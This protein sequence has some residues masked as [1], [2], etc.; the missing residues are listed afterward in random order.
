MKAAFIFFILGAAFGIAGLCCGFS[1]DRISEVYA[2][3][4]LWNSGSSV[5]DWTEGSSG[6]YDFEEEYTGIKSLDLAAGI[7]ECALIPYDG[8]TWLVTGSR[9]PSAF[10]CQ[11]KGSTLK[12]SF[13]GLRIF[14][15]GGG[16]AELAIY[17]PKDVRMEEINIEVGVGGVYSQDGA[18][19]CES[20]SIST[21]VGECILYADVSEEISIENGIGSTELTLVGEESDFNFDLELGIGEISIGSGSYSGFGNDKKID[22]DADVDVDVECGIGNVT[23]AFRK[24]AD[25]SKQ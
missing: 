1:L 5:L 7:S 22:N 10:S 2:E 8:D 4:R 3:G 9:L 24:N 25:D 17:V 23:I 14:G 15:F 20:L 18:V 16:D 6:S 11:K 12:V 21:G 13:N 19:Q